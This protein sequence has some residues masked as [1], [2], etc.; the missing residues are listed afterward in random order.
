VAVPVLTNEQR[1]AASAKAVQVRTKRAEI[2]RQLKESKISFN[3]VLSV[4]DSDE[5]VSGMRVITILESLPGIGKI[6][7]SALMETCDIALSRRM[8]GLGS[9]QA[10]K[11]KSALNGRAS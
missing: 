3:E 1:I 11:L 6:K 9:T 7:A 4:S 10:Q 2:R 5:I 8:K